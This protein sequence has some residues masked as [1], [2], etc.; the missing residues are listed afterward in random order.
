MY[1]HDPVSE[2]FTT[3]NFMIKAFDRLENV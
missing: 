1:I 3:R 2:G